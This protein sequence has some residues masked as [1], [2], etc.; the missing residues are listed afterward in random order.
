MTPTTVT[1]MI[2]TGTTVITNVVVAPS[3]WGL[4]VSCVLLLTV[5]VWESQGL[6]REVIIIIN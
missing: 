5:R 1:S 6:N 2:T 4:L 3:L